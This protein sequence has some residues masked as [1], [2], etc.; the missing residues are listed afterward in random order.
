VMDVGNL[1]LYIDDPCHRLHSFAGQIHELFVFDRS[2]AMP[3]H[4]SSRE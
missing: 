1:R 3:V 4:E 2:P